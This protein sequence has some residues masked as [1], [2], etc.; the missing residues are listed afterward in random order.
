MNPTWQW[1]IGG[2]ALGVIS[3][4][5]GWFLSWIGKRF[6]RIEAHLD[7]ISEQGCTEQDMQEHVAGALT[8]HEARYHQAR[9]SEQEA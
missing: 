7:R 2:I 5:L 6:D 9:P 4:L 1:I 3:Y 8:L